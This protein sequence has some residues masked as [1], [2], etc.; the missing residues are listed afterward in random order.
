MHRLAAFAFVFAPDKTSATSGTLRKSRGP[1]PVS[2]GAF[3]LRVWLT[4][5]AL[6]VSSAAP[7]GAQFDADAVE[8]VAPLRGALVLGGDDRPEVRTQFIGL[9]GGGK[10]RIVILSDGAD[11]AAAELAG[12]GAWGAVSPA[13]VATL[14]L[15][16]ADDAA[17]PEALAALTDATGAWLCGDAG[18]LAERCSGGPMLAGLRALLDRGGVVGGTASCARLAGRVV[19]LAG[20]LQP[21]LDL[22]P[23]AWIDAQFSGRNGRDRL[24]HAFA[25][26]P[27]VYCIG[28]DPGSALIVRGRSLLVSGPAEVVVAL[29]PS[30]DRPLRVQL[31]TA[32]RRGDLLA[33]GRA[34]QARAGAA[35]P[36]KTV[37]GPSVEHGSLVIVGGGGMPDDLL[38]RF[39]ELAGGPDAPIVY[40]PCTEQQVVLADRFVSVIEKAGAK[41]VHLL[42]TKDRRK[43]NDDEQ[44]LAPLKTARGIWFGGGRQWNLVDSYQNTTA[45]KLMHDVLSRGGVIGGSS[46][47]ASIQGDYMP[48]G[49]PLGN[50]NIIAEGYERGLGF[51]TGVAIDQHFAQRNRFAD[52][53]ALVRTWPQLL[54]IGIDEGTALIVRRNVAEIVGKGRVSFYDARRGVGADGRDF[55]PVEAGQSY[56]LQSRRIQ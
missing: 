32:E 43:A 54:G 14:K 55:E 45:H 39:I 56:D 31:L 21:G 13:S 40:I 47:G 25:R 1:Q 36:G 42:H 12:P 11:D 24:Q 37:R 50:F 4:V 5:W 3:N 20:R 48:R 53:T 26:R 22:L 23:G 30:T 2:P 51:L 49:D 27:D 46:A 19:D 28:I 17:R 10:A 8:P 44:F 38:A 7:A 35:F 52:M 16:Q 33:I 9:A 34:T 29:P 41:Q 18:R 6:L 15:R